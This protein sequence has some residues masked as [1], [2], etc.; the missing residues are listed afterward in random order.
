MFYLLL[1]FAAV[2][3]VKFYTSMSMGAL[4]K[5]LRE[6]QRDLEKVK[7]QRLEKDKEQK[8]MLEEEQ[9]FED[10]IRSMK[11]IIEDLEYRMTISTEEEKEVI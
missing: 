11:E 3:G 10:R 8:S 1:S 4:E 2:M 5:R 6:V 9:N 7:A